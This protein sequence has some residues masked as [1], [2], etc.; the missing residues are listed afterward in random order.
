MM[1]KQNSEGELTKENQ[2]PL[3]KGS[4]K[5]TLK[6]NIAELVAAH[7]KGGKFAKG[8]SAKKAHEMA[9]AV[10]FDLKRKARGGK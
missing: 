4:S 9:I 3:R 5:D 1:S 8:K 2:M 7:R 10:A 6:A